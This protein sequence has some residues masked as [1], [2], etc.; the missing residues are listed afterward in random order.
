MDIYDFKNE[1]AKFIKEKELKKRQSPDEYVQG[2][3]LD[4]DRF[5][6]AVALNYDGDS[7]IRSTCGALMGLFT[8]IIVGLQAGV[9][10]YEF[11]SRS[12]SK[13]TSMTDLSHY[14][15]SHFVDLNDLGIDF[16]FR[17]SDDG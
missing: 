6:T 16:A 12:S 17:L 8:M 1:T 2:K 14:D 7:V 13:I 9:K 5:G 10:S 4:F 15:N 3:I 11:I